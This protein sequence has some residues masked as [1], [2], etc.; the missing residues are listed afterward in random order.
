MDEQFYTILIGYG[1]K[2]RNKFIG[3]R[4]KH[5]GIE[6]FFYLHRVKLV[7]LSKIGS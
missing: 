4:K 5:K 2:K 3:F 7:Y 1:N 6:N